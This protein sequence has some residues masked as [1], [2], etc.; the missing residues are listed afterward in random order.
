M[1]TINTIHSFF[2]TSPAVRLLRAQSAPRILSFF[3]RSFKENQAPFLTEEKIIAQLA[4]FLKEYDIEEEIDGNGLLLPDFEM[5]AHLLVTRWTDKGFLK[6]Y[7]SPDNEILYELSSHS[8]RVIQWLEQLETREFVGT[9]SRFKDIF[10]KL[11]ELVANTTEDMDAK[12]HELEERKKTIDKEIHTILTTGKVSI[13][14]DYQI[15]SRVVELTRSAKELISDFKEVEDNFKTITRNIYLKHT[16][17]NQTK[18]AILGYTFDSLDELKESDQ[19]KSFYA[20]WEFLISQNR[21][22]LWKEL[23]QAVF[24]MLAD[25]NISFED[26][27]LRKIK[28]YLYR[29][30]Q[31]VNDANDRMSEK[32]SRVISER[33]LAERLKVKEAIDGI[34]KLALAFIERDQ[35]PPIGI[36]IEENEG[37]KMPLEKKLTLAAAET[38]VFDLQPGPASLPMDGEKLLELYSPHVVDKKILRERLLQLLELKEQVSLKEIIDIFPLEKGLSELLAY[39]SLADRDNKHIFN[40]HTPEWILFDP[41]QQK[42][43]QVPQIIFTRE[44][45]T[46]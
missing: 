46:K 7:E 35:F 21:R 13:Y 15:K 25:R 18:G 2:D 44:I 20:F 32:L 17:P 31:K 22:D 4:D 39:F 30:G 34:K 45:R 8:E 5:K 41:Y 10:N 23:V 43:I 42:H 37:V 14:D 40:P 33:E 6:N 12:I 38:P 9:E 28:H 11:Q 36:E 26:V 24:Q 19:G 27:F 29:A 1:L 3:Y 16:D